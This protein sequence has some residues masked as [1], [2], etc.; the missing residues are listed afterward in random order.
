MR[1]IVT[2]VAACAAIAAVPANAQNSA[3][4]EG[5]DDATRYALPHLL[6]GL[7]AA[8][9]ERLAPTGYFVTNRQ[10]LEA[11][12]A[13]GAAAHWPGARTLLIRMAGKNDDGD[14]DLSKMPDDALRPFV[15][16]VLVQMVSGKLKPEDCGKVE[17]GLELLDPLPADNF[18]G[19]VQFMMEIFGDKTSDR[20][21]KTADIPSSR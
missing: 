20:A 11:K 8:C 12:F 4:T 2:L 14:I 21:K 5:Y 17:R 13:D 3:D 9:D 19:L 16:A 18:A 15:D 6:E 7:Y 10:R 1:L